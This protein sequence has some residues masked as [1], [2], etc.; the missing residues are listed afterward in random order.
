[1]C[2]FL[3]FLLWLLLAE[4]TKEVESAAN[5]NT[6][7]YGVMCWLTAIVEAERPV[8]ELK[9]DPTEAVDEILAVNMSLSDPKFQ[10]L[11]N[12]SDETN[13][14]DKQD[15][16]I[17]GAKFAE[18]WQKSCSKWRAAKKKMMGDKINLQGGTNW[19]SIA[20]QS[21]RQAASIAVRQI[22]V[23]AVAW[24]ADYDTAV[25]IITEEDTNPIK[26]KLTAALYGG[27]GKTAKIKAGTTYKAGSSYADICVGTNKRLSLAG[28]KELKKPD[29]K[30]S[31]ATPLKPGRT[32]KDNGR[33]SGSHQKARHRRY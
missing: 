8:K 29:T 14:W 2:L 26:Q 32:S 5:A 18:D 20:A 10:A 17:T 12:D 1:M 7:Q 11:F 19:Q 31:R 30:A 6:K 23:Q 25:K 27:D 3:L 33:V 9:Q 22:A 24:K 21:A 13:T 16:K 15:A 28:D 4:T